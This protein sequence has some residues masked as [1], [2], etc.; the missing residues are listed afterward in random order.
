[1]PIGECKRMADP[2]PTPYVYN[3]SNPKVR[4]SRSVAMFKFHTP[5]N[6]N[7]EA[8]AAVEAYTAGTSQSTH[9]AYLDVTRATAMR[10]GGRHSA[11]KDCVHWCLP[12]PVDDWARML[13]AWWLVRD[14]N[15]VDKQ[16]LRYLATPC[17]TPLECHQRSVLRNMSRWCVNTSESDGHIALTCA[18]ALLSLERSSA[19]KR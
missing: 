3:L 2:L 18:A 11:R 12:G 10:P 1:M 16:T 6:T 17:N 7:E 19:T 4:A 13:L 8:R 15:Q 5:F 14:D 9:V